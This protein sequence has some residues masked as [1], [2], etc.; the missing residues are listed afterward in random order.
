MWRFV[1]IHLWAVKPCIYVS[2]MYISRSLH[3]LVPLIAL[4]FQRQ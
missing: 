3:I 2:R 1:W 4:L